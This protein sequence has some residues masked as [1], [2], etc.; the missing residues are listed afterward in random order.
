MSGSPCRQWLVFQ[1]FPGPFT[2]T[3]HLGWCPFLGFLIW[4]M[5]VAFKNCNT[6]LKFKCMHEESEY[7]M[8]KPIILYTNLKNINKKRRGKRRCFH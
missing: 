1:N 5:G 4:E 8:M 3:K 2:F 6:S 7:V